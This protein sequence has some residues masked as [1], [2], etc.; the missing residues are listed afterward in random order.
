MKLQDQISRSQAQSAKLTCIIVDDEPLARSRLERILSRNNEIRIIGSYGDPTKAH[1]HILDEQPDI[2]FLD[3]EMPG[4]NG[5]QI[6]KELR[7]ASCN[8]QIVFVT[9]NI[10]AIRQL[11]MRKDVGF[12][13]KPVDGEE[14]KG[15]LSECKKS[16]SKSINNEIVIQ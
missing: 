1:A 10:H 16:S 11:E 3:I 5:F 9:G 13:V 6:E 7:L 12:L 15:I 2:T 8:T 14:L 4:M